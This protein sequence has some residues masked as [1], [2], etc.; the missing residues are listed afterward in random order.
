MSLMTIFFPSVR[1]FCHIHAILVVNVPQFNCV[2][3]VIK[4]TALFAQEDNSN[5][6]ALWNYSHMLLN[7]LISNLLNIHSLINQLKEKL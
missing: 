5:I 6:F 3:I 4:L 2:L 1:F 7:C